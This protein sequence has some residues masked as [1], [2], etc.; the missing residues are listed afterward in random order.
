MAGA[1]QPITIEIDDQQIKNAL[2]QLL[3]ATGNLTPA[4]REIGEAMQINADRR[5]GQLI[6]PDHNHWQ[7]T[8]PV[9]KL[10]KSASPDPS[11]RANAG[12]ILQMYGNLRGSL[13]YQIDGNSLLF[14]TNLVYGAMMQFG[15]TK[16]QYPHLWGDIPARPF[17]GVSSEDRD[18]ILEIL[19]DHLQRAWS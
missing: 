10:Q 4:Y 17:L 14:G 13:H 5:F 2:Q 15:G 6:D 1:R 7:D 11:P 3:A 19:Q 12:N 18:D 16:A 8:R 9:T